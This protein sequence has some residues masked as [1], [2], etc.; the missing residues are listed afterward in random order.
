MVAVALACGVWGATPAF[1]NFPDRI[2]NGFTGGGAGRCGVCHVSSA[3]GGPR[4]AFGEDFRRGPNGI[5]GTSDDHTWS[6][7][8]AERDSDGDGW[9]NGQELGDPFRNWVPGGGSPPSSYR[10]NPGSSSSEP[11]N[12][13]LCNNS[14]YNDCASSFVRGQCTDVY[15]GSGRWNCSCGTGSTGAG[16]RRTRFH[17][18]TGGAGT[19]RYD[20]RST[21]SGCTDINECLSSP[22]GPGSCS[23]NDP[24]A[25]YTCNCNSGYQFNGS[26][27]VNV[28][29]CLSNPCG[30]AGTGCTDMTPGYTCTC[31][32]GFAFNGVTC[33]V[34][35]ACLAGTDDCDRNAT[36]TPIGASSWNC[37]CNAGWNGTG[38]IRNGT[39]DRCT[40][41]DECR[42]IRG[43]CDPG[44]CRN[45][46]GS[47]TCECP[48]GYQFNGRGCVD[49]DECAIRGICGDGG[50]GC[51]NNPGSYTCSCADGYMFDGTTCVDIDECATDPCGSGEC[52]QLP[53][54]GYVCAC[55]GGFEFDGTTCV[56]IDECTMPEVS[57]CAEEATCTNTPGEWRCSCNEGFTGD[58][59]T[60]L[61]VDECSTPGLNTCSINAVCANTPGSHTCTCSEGY[62]G[63]GVTCTDIN[64]CADGSARCGAGERCQNIP[65]APFECVCMNG[66]VRD[67]T[68]GECERAC[69]DGVRTPGEQC[70]TGNE[71]DPDGCSDEC[72][73]EPGWAC[74][75]ETVVVDDR[76]T[77]RSTC[78]NTCGDGFIQPSEECDDADANADEPD[79]CRTTCQAPR[80][81]DEIL[82]TGELCDEG[83]DNSDETADA[84]RSS[85]VPAFCGD[86]VVDTGENCDPGGGTELDAERC[87]VCDDPDAGPDA[88]TTGGGGG[89]GCATT[90]SR[91]EAWLLALLLFARRRR[92]R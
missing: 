18:W 50:T 24:A 67:E 34:Q 9:S 30:S 79:A 63:S 26:T 64:E 23:E 72:T 61:D 49:I 92:R 62:E 55:D 45:N 27:C 56:D 22:C 36:C 10:A 78:T 43:V 80:C 41:I 31:Q 29:E 7:W 25:G 14:A 8:L 76:E 59:Q 12:F 69:G 85:C 39:G 33:V 54:P 86:G 16:Y 32:S 83:M 84:C 11:S 20:I 60:C 46:P 38:T 90:G 53:P 2:P 35:N 51:R 65:G 81:G 40:D 48:R 58:G 1:A 28:N 89:G 87:S 82:D 17:T 68:T 19:R 37:T 42:T 73:I 4:T 57:L 77:I 91:G 70:D 44:T 15:N 3:G 74:F 88:S 47:Y 75:D 66:F 5:A 71:T 13:N 6:Q 52:M 21:I